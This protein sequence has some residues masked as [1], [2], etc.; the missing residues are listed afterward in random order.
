MEIGLPNDQL[1]EEEHLN[2][3]YLRFSE[4]IRRRFKKPWKRQSHASLKDSP[5]SL[6][7][8]PYPNT[9][10]KE[11]KT[12]IKELPKEKMTRA[13]KLIFLGRNGE[14]REGD[15]KAAFH[16]SLKPAKINNTTSRRF[17]NKLIRGSPLSPITHVSIHKSTWLTPK[18]VTHLIT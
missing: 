9:E 11:S 1:E 7:F 16:L 4:L 2:P 14:G 13:L 8:V 10:H 3:V 15:Y 18:E 12:K 5:F 17:I 6:C